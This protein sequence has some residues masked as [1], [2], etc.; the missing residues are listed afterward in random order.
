MCMKL[1]ELLSFQD[2]SKL[3]ANLTKKS[4]LVS[5]VI[6]SGHAQTRYCEGKLFQLCHFLSSVPRLLFDGWSY[7][8]YMTVLGSEDEIEELGGELV[9][10]AKVS[11]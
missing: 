11:V 4:K 6:P 1:K 7:Q 5:R 3:Y 10:V 8:D 2:G 9:D